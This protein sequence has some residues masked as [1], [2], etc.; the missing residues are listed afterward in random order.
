MAGRALSGQAVQA[1]LL[2]GPWLWYWREP[3]GAVKVQHVFPAPPV[4]RYQVM[5]R[6][7]ETKVL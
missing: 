7:I 3:S 4:D 1:A 6:A 2:G 5:E